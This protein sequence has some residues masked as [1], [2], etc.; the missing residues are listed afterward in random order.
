MGRTATPPAW[1]ELS[2]LDCGR[3]DCDLCVYLPLASLYPSSHK[4]P[5]VL[6]ELAEGSLESVCP[7]TWKL[8]PNSNILFLSLES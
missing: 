8:H 3:V 4:S 5:G 6:E 1:T 7:F 2:W